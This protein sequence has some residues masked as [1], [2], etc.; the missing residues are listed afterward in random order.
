M[1]ELP[2]VETIRR[3]LEPYLVGRRFAAVEIHQPRLRW[4]IADNL[5]SRLTAAPV[6]RLWR[7]GKYLLLTTESGTLIIHLGMSASLWL[8]PPDFSLRL[9]DHA[10][11]TLESG[12][13]LVFHDP[14]RFGALVWTEAPPETHPLLRD[15][16]VEPFDP[17][18]NGE[19]LYRISR[20]RRQAIKTFIMNQHL[21]VGI[22]NI[23]ANEA[24]FLAG[25]HP[26]RPASRI[27]KER[28]QKLAEG[29]R[30]TLTL[31]IEQGGTT[32]RDFSNATGQPGYFQ[33]ALQVYGRENQLC[34]RCATPIRRTTL[35][36][37]ATYYCP[38]CQK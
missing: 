1:P 38:R 36:Q 21:V 23:Y 31:A 9:H 20:N 33:L 28:H 37:R 25:I 15:L 13:R 27:S 34:L 18:F 10:V 30:Q 3:G 7:R 22:G 6:K 29:I 26:S 8:V 16:G 19:L 5:A 12:Q 17:E 14:R 24:L 11:F 4:Q 32:L 2:E 35:R